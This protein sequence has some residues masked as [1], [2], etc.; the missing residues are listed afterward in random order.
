MR[1][2]VIDRQTKKVMGSYSTRKKASTKADKLDL[3][4]G[5]YRYNVVPES[6]MN[7]EV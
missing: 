2:L 4:Y 1:Y 3:E 5:A 6:W 7:V